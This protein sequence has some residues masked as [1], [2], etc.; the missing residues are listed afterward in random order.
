MDDGVEWNHPDLSENYKE[1][2]SYDINS[3][4]RDPFPRSVHLLV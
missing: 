2:A 4:D 1:A 3:N